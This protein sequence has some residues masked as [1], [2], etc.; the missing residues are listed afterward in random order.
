MAKVLVVYY[1]LTGK[2][3]MMA[4]YLAEGL[5]FAAHE[6]VVK[7]TS[8]IVTFEDLNGYD[9]YLFG[10]PTYHQDMA[11]PV[12]T[13]LFQVRGADVAGKLAGAFGSYTHSGDAPAM[14]FD[15]M[16]YVYRMRPFYLGPFN[17]LEAK[18]GTQDGMRACHDYGRT[19]GEKLLEPWTPEETDDEA[20]EA[21]DSPT[22]W[23][24]T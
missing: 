11:G 2:T 15:T 24:L 21:P 14:V 16:R 7:K 10:S 4:E 6:A 13:F 9:G 3:Q 23:A 19:F 8:E 20:G 5:R 17:L 12:K 1:S 18:V 22:P